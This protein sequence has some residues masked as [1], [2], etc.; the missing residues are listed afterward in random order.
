MIHGKTNKNKNSSLFG[1]VT[2]N[3]R[4]SECHVLQV[5]TEWIYLH[6]K[7]QN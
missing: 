4:T 2:S 3:R 7:A 1:I 6:K 5:W